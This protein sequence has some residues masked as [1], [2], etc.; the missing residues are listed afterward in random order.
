MANLILWRHADAEVESASGKDFDRALTKK[1]RKDAIKIA[2]WLNQHVPANTEII[3]SPARRCLETAATLHDLN[4][5]KI[6]VAEFL[7]VD[8]S[9]ERIAKEV[10]NA[11]S[12][13]TILIIGH[14]P[15]LGMLIAKLLGL[16]ERT[17]VVKKGA[18]WWLRQRY[19]DD[20]EKTTLQTYLFAVQHPDL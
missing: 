5:I 6:K 2:K 9:V 20:A 7:S 12:S 1:G 14:Q 16:N 3:C 18:A 19:V 15:T 8:S 10:T 11:D 4:G 13:K 17:C